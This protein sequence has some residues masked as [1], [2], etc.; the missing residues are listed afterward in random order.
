M[1][2]FREIPTIDRG[3]GVIVTPLVGSAIGSERLTIGTTTFPPGTTIALHTHNC[4]ES[5]CVVEGEAVCE[6]DGVLHELALYDTTF[7]PQGIPHRFI[8]KGEQ[9][10]RILW[11]YASGHVTRTVVATGETADH[12]SAADRPAISRLT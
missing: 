3:N 10:L 1:V 6:I 11:T 8:N 4:D 7:V 2:H 9:P 5:V 12:L